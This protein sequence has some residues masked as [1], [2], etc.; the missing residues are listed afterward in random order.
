M[1]TERYKY[2]LLTDWQAP[3]MDLDLARNIRFVQKT[4]DWDSYVVL[5]LECSLQKPMNANEN[6]MTYEYDDAII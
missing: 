4:D 2:L 6:L 1:R 5:I 3:Q